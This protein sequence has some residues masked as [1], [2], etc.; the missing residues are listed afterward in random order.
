M[1]CFWLVISY[2][3]LLAI[4]LFFVKRKMCPFHNDSRLLRTQRLSYDAFYRNQHFCS[5]SDSL[6]LKAEAVNGVYRKVSSTNR[7]MDHCVGGSEN[8]CPIYQQFKKMSKDELMTYYA[9][10]S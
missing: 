7:Y 1:E 3:F 6:G 10:R 8:E 2:L 9:K 4:Y 5:V